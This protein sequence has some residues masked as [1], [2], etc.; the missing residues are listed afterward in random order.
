MSVPTAILLFSLFW[1]A[2]RGERLFGSLLIAHRPRVVHDLL[3]QA[4][5]SL[6]EKFHTRL[7]GCGE[8][9]GGAN[10][11]GI[12]ACA[13]RRR[14]RAKIAERGVE[15]IDSIPSRSIRAVPDADGRD[16]ETAAAADFS[17][18]QPAPGQRI[19]SIF[20]LRPPSQGNHRVVRFP[21]KDRR[22]SAQPISLAAVRRT[23]GRGG[24]V[25]LGAHEGLTQC[26]R[27]VTPKVEAFGCLAF[28]LTVARMELARDGINAP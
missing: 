18:Y 17:E 11:T 2:R 23:L 19:R 28:D 12:A 20:I 4:R 7:R 22:C 10:V 21:R 6:S 24:V 13:T 3:G 25:E 16:R 9:F 26:A 14:S 5:M 15:R 8:R 27:S 1:Q